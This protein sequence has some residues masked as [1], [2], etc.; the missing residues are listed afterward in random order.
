[1]VT[2]L[3]QIIWLPPTATVGA[4]LLTVTTTAAVA[5]LHGDCWPVVVSVSV[6][7]PFEASAKDG[8]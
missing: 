4:A 2:S 8:V 6:T 7:L 3:E 1:M 5:A